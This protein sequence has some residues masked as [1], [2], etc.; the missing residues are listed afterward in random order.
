MSR[1][2]QAARIF[3]GRGPVMA[4]AIGVL[5]LFVAAA[6]AAGLVAPYDPNAQDLTGVLHLPSAAHPLGQDNLGRDV[7]SRLMFGGQVSLMVSFLAGSLAAVIGI[8]LGL[9]SGYRGGWPRRLIMGGTDVL[10]S[11]PGLV[12]SLV[13]AAIL[14][15][16]VPSLV[17]AIGLSMVPTYVRMV[18]GLVLSLR[19]NDYIVAAR[20]I[21]QKE[22]LI[23]L[24]HLLP[25]SIPTLIVVYTINLG[26]AVLTESTLSYLG[27]GISPPTASWGSMVSDVYPYLLRAP[28][29][30]I[31][32]GICIILII[33]AFNL[34]GDGLRDALDPR[35]RGRL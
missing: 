17:L 1:W 24:K 8:A 32:P 27:V 10:L 35:L 18:N 28:W 9:G 23:L 19:E 11:I 21:G 4:A 31:S 25:N 33:V 20:L 5:I 6:I 15:G 22:R 12:F 26:N 29:L 16:G 2:R 13:L 7:L 14:G 3:F 30:V 34:V